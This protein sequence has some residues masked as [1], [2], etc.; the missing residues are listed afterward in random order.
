[1]CH[2]TWQEVRLGAHSARE[3]KRSSF[4]HFWVLDTASWCVPSLHS[5]AEILPGNTTG[6]GDVKPPCGYQTANQVPF[7]HPQTHRKLGSSLWRMKPSFS[8]TEH[9]VC[10]C[11]TRNTGA[12]FPFS[13]IKADYFPNFNLGIKIPHNCSH[14]TTWLFKSSSNLPGK[15][16]NTV[17]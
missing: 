13:L 9:G 2:F 16:E 8:P 10:D 6:A 15:A 7:S 1:M 4:C 17:T 3:R 14:I 5:R 11:P 12:D